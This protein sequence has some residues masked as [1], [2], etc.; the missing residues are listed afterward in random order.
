MLIANVVSNLQQKYSNKNSIIVSP[1]QKKEEE[2]EEKE[3][4]CERC[5][6]LAGTQRLKYCELK[7][8]QRESAFR[9]NVKFVFK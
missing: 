2:E 1:P 7:Q 3:Q 6:I 5:M 8:A 4:L 9:N